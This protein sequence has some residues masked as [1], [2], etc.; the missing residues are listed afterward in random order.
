MDSSHK[1]LHLLGEKNPFPFSKHFLQHKPNQTLVPA[2]AE[3]W[4]HILLPVGWWWEASNKVPG[5][6]GEGY[7]LLGSSYISKLL[8]NCCKLQLSPLQQCNLVQI[9]C[10]PGYSRTNQRLHT[11]L[12]EAEAELEAEASLCQHH[13]R[14]ARPQLAGWLDPWTANITLLDSLRRNHTLE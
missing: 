2:Q 12:K 11:L 10:L 6:C 9:E 7:E 13:S 5:P 3:K 14:L 4:R 8:A 1:F